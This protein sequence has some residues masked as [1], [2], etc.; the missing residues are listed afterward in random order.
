MKKSTILG[1]LL[2]VAGLGVWFGLPAYR[3]SKEK[4]FAAQAMEALQKGEN[5]KALLSAQ[6]VLVLNSNNVTACRVM[7]ELADLSRSPHALVWRRRVAEIEPTRSNKLV[8]ASV[9]LRFEQPPFPLAVQTLK[10]LDSTTNDVA[11]HLVSAQLALKQ[12]RFA[13]GEKHL[14]TAIRMEPANE[15]HRINLGVVQLESRDPAVA[16]VARAEMEQR[17]NSVQALRALMV[18]HASRRR[19]AEAEKCSTTLLKLPDS[20]WSDRLE[21]LAVL[22]GAQSPQFDAFLA[23]LQ[24]VAGTNAFTASELVTRMTELGATTNALH[25]VKTLPAAIQKEQPLPVATANA[26]FSAARWRELEELLNRDQWP[27]RDYLRKALLANAVRKQG[28]TEA[29]NAHWR[30][31]VKIASENQVQLVALAQLSNSWGWTNETE[32]MLWRAAKD[33]PKEGWPLESLHNGYMRHRNTA[34]VMAV[35]VLTLER[36]PNNVAAQNNWASTALLLNTNLTRA[37]ELARKVYEHTP[38]HYAFAST[39]AWSLQVQGKS[40]EALKIMETLKPEEL[41]HPALAGYYGTILL[42]NGQKAKAR[43]Y[44]DRTTGA[45]LLPEEMK[46]IAD[47]RKKL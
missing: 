1:V 47:A 22:R 23:G 12:G 42:A 7:A 29:A 33:F 30:D 17:T 11:F 41:N 44:L 43:I 18:H 2:I 5:R 46:L 16:A 37:H 25:W 10:E 36:D 32:A 13:D 14:Q 35:N 38:N 31:A 4:K 27:D 39:Y 26:Y 24:R 9:A 40:A 15:S 45:Q 19:F 3:A 21:H 20:V 28:G 34:G 8:F 6:Q